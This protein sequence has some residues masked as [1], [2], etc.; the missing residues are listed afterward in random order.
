MCHMHLI[1]SGPTANLLS[2]DLEWLLI[3]IFIYF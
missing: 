1:P 3:L 2:L